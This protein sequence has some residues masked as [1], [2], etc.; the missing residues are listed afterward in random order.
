[1]RAILTLI[2]LTSSLYHYENSGGLYKYRTSPS[3]AHTHT[4]TYTHIQ[5]EIG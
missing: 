5:G 3:Y 1:M 4:N 2:E